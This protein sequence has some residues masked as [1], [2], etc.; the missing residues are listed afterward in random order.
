M[1]EAVKFLEI[2]P[3]TQIPLSIV[4]EIL[5]VVVI[6]LLDKSQVNTCVYT[7]GMKEEA[8]TK[9]SLRPQVI[10]VSILGAICLALPILAGIFDIGTGTDDQAGDMIGHLTPGFSP[11]PFWESFEPSELGEP[12]L[13]AL[14]VAIGIALFAWGYYQLV[15][16]KRLKKEHEEH[17]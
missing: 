6:G 16:K 17:I 11:T 15:Y 8:Q 1:D 3:I 9:K 5:T 13:F 7:G 4:E 2:L 14:Q 10:L 12:L